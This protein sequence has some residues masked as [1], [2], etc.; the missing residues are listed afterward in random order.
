MKGLGAD[1]DEFASD[2][3]AQDQVVAV[4]FS[5]AGQPKFRSELAM[6]GKFSSEANVSRNFGQRKTGEKIV[7]VEFLRLQDVPRQSSLSPL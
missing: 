5:F 7:E 4:N 2:L 3:V 1:D 6:A